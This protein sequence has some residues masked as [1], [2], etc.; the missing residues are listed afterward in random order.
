[1]QPE[2]MVHAA[3]AGIPP[4]DVIIDNFPL[5]D[6]WDDR[7][8]YV[9]ELGR[10]MDPLPDIIAATEQGPGLCQPGLAR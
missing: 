10:D 5:L 9:I 8:R 7:Y 1:M 3:A 2:Q 4:I 6:E